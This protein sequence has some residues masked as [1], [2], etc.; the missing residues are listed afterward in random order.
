M[1]N[2]TNGKWQFPI[3]CGK[4]KAEMAKV[5]LFATNGNGKQKFVFIG[6]QTIN[7]NR[8]MTFQ[9][10]CPSMCI[11]WAR[12]QRFSSRPNERISYTNVKYVRNDLVY[13]L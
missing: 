3:A 9:Q 2:G 8:L 10:T 4:W 13:L 6:W 5:R 1:E 11:I 7:S 12:I